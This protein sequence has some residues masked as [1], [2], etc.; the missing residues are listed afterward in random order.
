MWETHE[1]KVPAWVSYPL[2]FKLESSLSKSPAFPDPLKTQLSSNL[3]VSL[4]FLGWRISAVL[5][6]GHKARLGEGVG[7]CKSW[8]GLNITAKRKLSNHKSSWILLEV[9]QCIVQLVCKISAWKNE[10]LLY[11][12]EKKIFFFDEPC[13]KSLSRFCSRKI[14][15]NFFPVGSQCRRFIYD[16]ILSLPALSQKKLLFCK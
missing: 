7:A 4:R 5:E 1:V 14:I 3:T 12:T 15:N 8:M 13:H 16:L 9:F 6:E 2:K 10:N 11:K